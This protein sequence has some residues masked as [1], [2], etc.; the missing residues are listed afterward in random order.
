MACK[1]CLPQNLAELKEAIADLRKEKPETL[2]AAM[3]ENKKWV[4]STRL[5]KWNAL[6]VNEWS[7]ARPI[8]REEAAMLLAFMTVNG[9]ANAADVLRDMVEDVAL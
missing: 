7:C 8:S 5:K 1:K 3:A 4:T 2:A 9:M 6:R